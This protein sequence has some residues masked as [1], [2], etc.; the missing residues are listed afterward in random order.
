M[1][2]T[3]ASNERIWGTY[4][5]DDGDDY[6]ISCKKAL[7]SV[8]GNDA[9]LGYVAGS[10]NNLGIPNEFRPR[11]VKC[12]DA[13]GHARWVT[14]YS[15]LATLWTTPG[16]TIELDYFGVDTLFTSTKYRR[17]ENAGRSITK[18]S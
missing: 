2:S 8:V 15:L 17:S 12:V 7:V 9:K 11:K 3:L 16:T 5:T 6:N 1:A 10:A 4:I 14:C 13:A 18:A